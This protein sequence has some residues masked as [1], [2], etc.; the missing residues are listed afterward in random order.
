MDVP[1]ARTDRTFDY[2]IPPSLQGLVQVG[3]RVMVPFGPRKLQGFVVELAKEA[4]FAME[5]VKN[6]LDVLDLE[7]PLTPELVKLARWMSERY[8]STYYGAL[9]AMIPSALRSKYEKRLSLLQQPTEGILLDSGEVDF[10][11]YLERYTPVAWETLKKKF[12]QAGPWIQVGLKERWLKVEDNLVN[13]TGKKKI[14]LVSPALEGE[15]LNKI[16]L[17]LPKNA[18][19]QH[20]I[21]S[22][23]IKNPKEV[24]QSHLLTDLG[25]NSQT[26][27]SLMEKGWL[28]G[29]EKEDYRDPFAGRTF[30]RVEKHPFTLQQEKV[31]AGIAQ[32]MKEKGYFPCLIHGVTG[33]GKTEVYLEIMERVV[34]TR[35]RSHS[36]GSGNFFNPTNGKPI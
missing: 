17:G 12:P 15:E 2:K 11:R 27:K 34:A 31:I 28:K 20:E 25:T 7:P 5:K 33:S 3:S 19:R 1:V 36:I 32:G 26:V 21:L 4:N 30:Q 14:L 35:K 9:Q 22:Y 24:P 29:R 6:L 13:R 8:M 18:L 16:L 23:F 10:Y